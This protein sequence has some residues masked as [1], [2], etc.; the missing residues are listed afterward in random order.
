MGA[1]SISPVPGRYLIFHLADGTYA[2]PTRCVEEIVPM[3]VLSPVPGA[4]CLTS[5]FL[6]VGGQLVAVISVLR[7]LEMP[8]RARELYATLVIVAALLHQVAID[9]D[10]VSH[11]AVI[12]CNDNLK[13][14]VCD[15]SV[16]SGRIG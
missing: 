16:F 1:D 4:S 14:F 10:G 5:G 11:N 7:L 8:D 6:D 2:V 3:A 12:A 9:N 13:Y 15:G